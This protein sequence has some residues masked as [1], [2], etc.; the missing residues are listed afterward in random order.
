[1]KKAM[2]LTGVA[3]SILLP[4]LVCAQGRP[5]EKNGPLV[6]IKN[7]KYGYIN[8]QGKMVIKPR[9]EWGSDFIGGSANVFVC[10]R[11]VSINELGRILPL[12]WTIGNELSPRS[13]GNNVG[14]VDA[15]GTFIIP[16]IYEEALEFADGLAAVEVHELWGFIDASG[17]ELI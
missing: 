12:R 3:A 6:V 1:M 4:I 11:M 13:V 16:A 5:S 17:H 9:F 15:S 7:G 8:H 2:I 10:S 14:F